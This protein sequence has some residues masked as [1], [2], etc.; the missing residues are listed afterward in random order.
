MPLMPLNQRL[1][2]RLKPAKD[3]LMQTSCKS[4]ANC[5]HAANITRSPRP[6]EVRQVNHLPNLI[7]QLL[8][9]ALEGLLP[10]RMR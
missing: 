5:V 8:V 7:G 1:S 6:P 4:P 3:A 10:A 9:S 2:L